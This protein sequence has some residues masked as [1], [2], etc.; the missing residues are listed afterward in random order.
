MQKKFIY[1]GMIIGSIVGG[2]APEL[3]GASVFSFASIFT[4]A[5]GAFI[6]IYIGYKID[7]NI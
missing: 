6:G 2:Y 3:F 4:G 1:L 7:E 5:L